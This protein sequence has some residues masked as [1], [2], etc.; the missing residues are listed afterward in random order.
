MFVRL[1]AIHIVEFVMTL[2]RFFGPRLLHEGSFSHFPSPMTRSACTRIPS[3]PGAP[4]MSGYCSSMSPVILVLL[5]AIRFPRCRLTP[6]LY[7]SYQVSRYDTTLP[8]FPSKSTLSYLGH[9]FDVNGI[10]IGARWA[11]SV[12]AGVFIMPPLTE[13]GEYCPNFPCR[14]I[15]PKT[16]SFCSLASA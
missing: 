14:Y 7:E 1:P 3:I 13:A 9:T 15:V 2:V 5:C 4:A 11:P 6:F 12:I 16:I 10:R 8:S